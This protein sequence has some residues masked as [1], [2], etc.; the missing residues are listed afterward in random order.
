MISYGATL[1]LFVVL[2]FLTLPPRP[3]LRWL[4]IPLIGAGI[5]SC[6]LSVLATASLTA[7]LATLPYPALKIFLDAL[8]TLVFSNLTFYGSI[9]IGIGILAC[10]ASFVLPEPEPEK[11]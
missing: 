3:M 5:V 7:F 4:S 9:G 6:V 2:A 8:G 1:L 10:I 11:D